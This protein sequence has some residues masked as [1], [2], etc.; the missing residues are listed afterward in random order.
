MVTTPRIGVEARKLTA[1]VLEY[2]DVSQ[3]HQEIQEI[4]EY[5]KFQKP[6]HKNVEIVVERSLVT[7]STGAA[8]VQAAQ[9]LRMSKAELRNTDPTSILMRSLPLSRKQLRSWCA[10]PWSPM[11]LQP[12][13]ANKSPPRPGMTQLVPQPGCAPN[14]ALVPVAGV[15]A[16]ASAGD[17]YL[18]LRSIGGN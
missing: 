6:T 17:K 11:K 1:K 10:Y 9:S 2:F 4:Q 16:A 7:R 8:P 5:Q 18:M 15:A 12:T 13:F 14:G 3:H